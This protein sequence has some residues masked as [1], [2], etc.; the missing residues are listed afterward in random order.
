MR[1]DGDRGISCSDLEAQNI[2]YGLSIIILAGD[3]ESAEQVVVES[4]DEWESSWDNQQHRAYYKPRLRRAPNMVSLSPR[5][6]LQHIVCEKTLDFEKAHEEAFLSGRGT[7]TVRTLLLRFV[8]HL[9]LESMSSRSFKVAVGICRVLHKY[10]HATTKR[11][12]GLLYQRDQ[13]RLVEGKID[14]H[15]DDEYRREKM[16]LVNELVKRFEHFV[17]VYYGPRRE[18]RFI[19]DARSRE[20]YDYIKECLTL[21]TPWGTEH[22]LP[23]TFEPKKFNIAGL[24]FV[25]RR[26]DDRWHRTEENRMHTIIDPECFARLVKACEASVPEQQVDVPQFKGVD[27][28]GEDDSSGRLDKP[29]DL[30]FEQA[31]HIASELKRRGERRKDAL[32]PFLK[33]E[34]DGEERGRLRT[35]GANSLRLEL[36][37]DSKLIQVFTTDR[38][39]KLLLASLRLRALGVA[40]GERWNS[41]LILAGGR[42]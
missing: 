42:S 10:D 38:E 6:L 40:P 16:E 28:G 31:R 29:P 2:T 22:T 24:I 13:D 25:G 20:W 33:V 41:S 17:S 3:R 39:G 1:H 26:C 23:P 18:K 5:S 35:A 9:L 7:L 30:T 4:M 14:N 32:A 27:A 8:K 12:C 11:I 37:A 34:I 21:L 19:S 36:N 15:T